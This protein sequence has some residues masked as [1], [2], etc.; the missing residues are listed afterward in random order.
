MK[1]VRL[2]ET[3]EKGDLISIFI[4]ILSSKKNTN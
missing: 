2:Y 1:L 4:F 3:L